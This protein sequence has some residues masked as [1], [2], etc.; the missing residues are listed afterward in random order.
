M[1]KGKAQLKPEAF[2]ELYDEKLKNNNPVAA[3][4]KA[5]QEHESEFGEQRYSGYQ[6][7]RVI[8]SRIINKK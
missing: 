6:S 7:F 2:N 8:R 1:V 5:E 4:E 3:Y